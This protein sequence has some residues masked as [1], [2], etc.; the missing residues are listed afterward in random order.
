MEFI[1]Q[2]ADER[3]N[4]REEDRDSLEGHVSITEA[5]AWWEDMVEILT[6]EMGRLNL[7]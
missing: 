5:P 3:E 4:G 1:W 2:W 7:S 6:T